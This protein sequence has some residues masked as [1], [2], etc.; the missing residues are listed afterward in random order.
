MESSVGP[1]AGAVIWQVWHA[2]NHL[3]RD[4]TDTDLVQKLEENIRVRA[5]VV[6]YTW[7]YDN[8]TFTPYKIDLDQMTQTNLQSKF[9]R[10]IR[11]V[12]VE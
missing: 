3:W 10:K 9:V 11:R 8:T 6:E 12:R 1:I 2:K 4:M 5:V 7:P